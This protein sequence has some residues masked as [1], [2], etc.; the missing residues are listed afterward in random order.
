MLFSKLNS[1]L[2]GRIR[3][4]VENDGFE[5]TVGTWRLLSRPENNYYFD[6]G[7]VR[8]FYW[9]GIIPASIFVAVL[10]LMMYYCYRKEQYMALVLIASFS[11]YSI[12]EAHA[13]SVYLARNYML[14]LMGMYWSAILQDKERFE[15][16][17]SV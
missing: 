14:F 12:I 4:L 17:E 3:I 8:L 15:N 7:W 16:N 11:L 2:N 9:Y 5:V 13:I 1:V 10:L 6:M